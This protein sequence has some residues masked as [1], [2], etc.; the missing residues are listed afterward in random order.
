MDRLL[1]DDPVV[2]AGLPK[3]GRPAIPGGGLNFLNMFKNL[4]VK[5]FERKQFLNKN[6]HHCFYILVSYK[7]N[8]F[9]ELC[10]GFFLRTVQIKINSGVPALS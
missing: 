4:N 9:F 5:R 7:Q 10:A 8:S 6:F 3:F 1:V 2:F